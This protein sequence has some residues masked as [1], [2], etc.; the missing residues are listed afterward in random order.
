MP[1]PQDALQPYADSG[2]CLL[3]RASAWWQGLYRDTFGGMDNA[4]RIFQISNDT[5]RGG[6]R[7]KGLSRRNWPAGRDHHKYGVA[8]SNTG[9]TVPSPRV[10]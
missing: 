7:R 3:E 10:R 5:H 1:L 4:C 9:T 6:G 8:W 2:N